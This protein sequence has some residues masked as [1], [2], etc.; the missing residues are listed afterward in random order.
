MLGPSLLWLKATSVVLKV[1]QEEDLG[2]SCSVPQNVHPRWIKVEKSFS[3]P[4][5]QIYLTSHGAYEVSG[6]N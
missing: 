2:K 4:H 5:F 6:E 1:F 3:F